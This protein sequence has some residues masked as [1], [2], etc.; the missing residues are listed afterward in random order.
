MT[1]PHSS[2]LPCTGAR[3]EA[4][5]THVKEWDLQWETFTSKQRDKI[6]LQDLFNLQKSHLLIVFLR[7]RVDEHEHSPR[8]SSPCRDWSPGACS[9]IAPEP[10]FSLLSAHRSS[11]WSPGSRAIPSGS[12]AWSGP[13]RTSSWCYPWLV[14]T[15]TVIILYL[16]LYYLHFMQTNNNNKYQITMIKITTLS[17]LVLWSGWCAVG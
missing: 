1:L 2:L 14:N 7:E 12:P 6:Y 5:T 10:V 17:Y 16:I 8:L 11:A 9:D 15:E 4:Q 13:S 3:E